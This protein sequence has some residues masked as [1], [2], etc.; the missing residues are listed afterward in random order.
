MTI[1]T[2]TATE[3]RRRLAGF[4]QRIPPRYTQEASERWVWRDAQEITGRLRNFD[5]LIQPELEV[6]GGAYGTGIRYSADTAI[7]VAYPL[8]EEIARRA[9]GADGQDLAALLAQLH[10]LADDEGTIDGMFPISMAASRGLPML[11]PQFIQIDEG[12]FI[13]EFRVEIHFMAHDLVTLDAL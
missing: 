12:A 11:I 9:V 7:R 10:E 2:T 4:I 13:V 8:D 5:V 6:P 3:I 1:A